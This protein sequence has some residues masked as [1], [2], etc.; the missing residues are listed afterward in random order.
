AEQQ[1]SARERAGTA[2]VQR[3]G[4]DVDVVG[5]VDEQGQQG[6]DALR[7][8]GWA[9]RALRLAGGAGGVDH[10]AARV[11]VLDVGLARRGG[12]DVGVGQHS[13]GGGISGAAADRDN[14]PHFLQPVAQR[15]E[16]GRVVDVH[17]DDLGVAVVDD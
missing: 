16:H 8:L 5:P 14:V 12:H 17:V 9:D 15:G 10:R 7:V 3:A 6:A 11:R 2:V 13:L 4:G 1:G